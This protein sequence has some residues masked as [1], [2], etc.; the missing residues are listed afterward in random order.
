M[1]DDNGC[2]CA[3]GMI[4]AIGISIYL[5]YLLGFKGGM[6]ILGIVFLIWVILL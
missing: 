5:L 1:S 2:G 6:T 3:M 4:A